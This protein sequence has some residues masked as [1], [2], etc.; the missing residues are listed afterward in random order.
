VGLVPVSGMRSPRA[1]GCVINTI[2][3]TTLVK[4]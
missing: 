3:Q 4:L 1:V 2:V